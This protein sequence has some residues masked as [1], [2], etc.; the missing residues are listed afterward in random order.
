MTT[1]EPSSSDITRLLPRPLLVAIIVVLLVIVLGPVVY[2]LFS[3]V[4]SDVAVA[5]GR[6]LPDRAPPRQLPQGVDDRR[7]RHRADEQVDR[8]RRPSRS[9]ARSSPSRPPTCWCA[10]SSAAG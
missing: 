1:V 2:M 5:V 8:L 10:T 6:V 9:S 3:S 7:P 4:N